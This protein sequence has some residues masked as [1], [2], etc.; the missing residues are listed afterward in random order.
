MNF[1]IFAELNSHHHN[2]IFEHFQH[3][4]RRHMPICH[5]CFSSPSPCASMDQRSAFS[6]HFTEAYNRRAVFLALVTS[7]GLHLTSRP[8][9]H[10][11]WQ[12]NNYFWF[13]EFPQ[14][15][16]FC[17]QPYQYTPPLPRTISMRFSGL[18]WDSALL[19]MCLT[20]AFF[21]PDSIAHHATL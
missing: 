15:T 16:L 6:G 13:P 20:G 8:S 1:S 18:N 17:L 3:P 14:C 7:P 5:S 19:W 9:P 2:L 4:K 21:A 12:Q 11:T 10:P